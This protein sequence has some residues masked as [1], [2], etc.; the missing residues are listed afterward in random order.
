MADEITW[1]Q[2]KEYCKNR[3]LGIVTGEFYAM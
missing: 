1:E 2:V 3:C